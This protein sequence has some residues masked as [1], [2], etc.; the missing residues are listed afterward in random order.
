MN[1]LYICVRAAKIAPIPASS[2]TTSTQKPA[3][4]PAQKPANIPTQQPASVPAQKPT[5]VEE[6]IQVQYQSVEESGQDMTNMLDKMSLNQHSPSSPIQS[7][8]PAYS[9][10][11]AH[12]LFVVCI[13]RWYTTNKYLS[14][15][16]IHILRPK[17]WILSCQHTKYIPNLCIH[18][19]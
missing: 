2:S 5:T 18:L 8:N 3:N 11:S 9:Q 19:L 17:Y 14:K 15:F 16:W 7:N 1:D 10:S 12:K 13:F 6:N 4:I